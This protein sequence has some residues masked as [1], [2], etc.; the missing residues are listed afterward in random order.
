MDSSET[1]EGKTSRRSHRKS[2]LGCNNCKARRV[3]K[4]PCKF[5]FAPEFQQW[6]VVPPDSNVSA[7]SK[8]APGIADTFEA[9]CI[10]DIAT[11]VDCLCWVWA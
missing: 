11:L 2:R 3:T 9:L 4:C 7:V 10:G 8:V 5:N 1:Y 6:N